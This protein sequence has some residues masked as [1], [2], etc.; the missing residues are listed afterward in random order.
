MRHH[1]QFEIIC[2]QIDQELTFLL[3]YDFTPRGH[4]RMFF[5]K[6]QWKLQVFFFKFYSKENYPAKEKFLEMFHPDTHANIACMNVRLFSEIIF[7]SM[8]Y[9]DDWV[10]NNQVTIIEE[11]HYIFICIAIISIQWGLTA[12]KTNCITKSDSLWGLWGVLNA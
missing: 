6:L 10:Y 4:S 1:W 8:T 12:M 7:K 9:V 2:M 3:F 5:S 11:D